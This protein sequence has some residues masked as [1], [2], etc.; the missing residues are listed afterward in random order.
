M[1]ALENSNIKVSKSVLVFGI[2]MILAGIFTWFNP[3]TALLAMALYLGIVF[4][5]GGV[6]YLSAFFSY[7]SGGLLALGLL[8]IIVGVILMTNLGAGFIGHL[9]IMRR[10]YSN[11][12]QH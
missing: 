9:G 2:L 6:G 5:L 11:C 3:D 7:P 8:D 10:R 1:T 12:V 4:L